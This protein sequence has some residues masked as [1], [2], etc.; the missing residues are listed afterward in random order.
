MEAVAAWSRTRMRSGRAGRT[1]LEAAAERQH[2]SDVGDEEGP[3]R[4][5]AAAVGRRPLSFPPLPFA[6]LGC[7][8][9]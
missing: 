7:A 8:L 9:A 1:R 4:P 3:E 2:L 5:A 6:A